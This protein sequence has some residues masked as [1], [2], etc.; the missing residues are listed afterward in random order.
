VERGSI[1]VVEDI[2]ERRRAEQELAEAKLQAEAASHAKSAFLASM[3]HEIRTPLNAV[4]GLAHLLRQAG[5]QPAQREQYLAHLTDAAQALAGIVSDVLDL[6]KIEAAKL[7]LEQV[8]F[9]LHALVDEVQRSQ[10]ALCEA[11]GLQLHCKVDPAVPRHVQGDPVRVRQI[12]AN[13]LG[14]AVKFT[15]RGTVTLR[16]LPLGGERVRLEVTDTGI[17]IDPATQA[18]LF[19]PFAQADSSTTRRFGGTGLGLSICHELALL[20]GGQV[21]LRSQPGQGSCFWADLPLPPA[22][23]PLVAAPAPQERPLA[24]LCVLVAEDNPI[25]ML[26]TNEMLGRL[27]AQ[28]LQAMDGQQAMHSAREHAPRLHAVLMD[29]HMPVMDGLAAA[30]AL[31][32]DP[33]TAGLPILALTAAAL[34]SERDM[35]L[36]AGMSGFIAKPVDHLELLRALMPY[37]PR[38]AGA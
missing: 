31:R 35:A 34:E 37:L 8:P 19:Q 14:N 29:L 6:S 26:I 5:E 10:G 16:V 24:G 28:V 21:G 12:L 1:W 23:Q 2:T 17:G 4:L 15:E 20:M 30:R 22:S 36:A 32:A 9:D 33:H 11:R 7:Q 18:R 25:N 3:S 38:R 27:G 13:Y